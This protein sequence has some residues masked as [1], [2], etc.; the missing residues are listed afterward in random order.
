MD[1]ISLPAIISITPLGNSTCVHLF[2]DTDDVNDIFV[3]LRGSV[4]W[5]KN[6]YFY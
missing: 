5:N 6:L 2:C 3:H 4:I 1:E